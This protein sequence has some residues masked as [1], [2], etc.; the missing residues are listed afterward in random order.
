MGCA[1]CFSSAQ[2]TLG[3]PCFEFLRCVTFDVL[4]R[5]GAA[6][7]TSR[8]DSAHVRHSCCSCSVVA[9]N[10]CLATPGHER[11]RSLHS[12]VKF[13]AGNTAKVEKAKTTFLQKDCVSSYHTKGVQTLKCHQDGWLWRPLNSRPGATPLDLPKKIC[14]ARLNLGR[15]LIPVP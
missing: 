2:L 13:S 14:G 9:A 5:R 3:S 11:Q 4:S 1:S 15:S 8:S 6:V 12:C 7:P 10:R